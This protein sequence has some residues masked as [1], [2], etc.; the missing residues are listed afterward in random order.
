M[1][2]MP[3]TYGAV[4]GEGGAVQSPVCRD[5][6]P[7]ATGRRSSDRRA[8]LAGLMGKAPLTPQGLHTCP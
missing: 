6:P 3:P 2:C 1:S 7:E 8:A 4:G 5:C